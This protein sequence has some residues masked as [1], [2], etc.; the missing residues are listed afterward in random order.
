MNTSEEKIKETL[1]R[2]VGE[3]IEPEHLAKALRSGKKLRVKFGIDPTSPDLHL[4]HAVILRKLRQ[5][6]S[7]GHKAVL[8]IGDFTARIGDPSGREGARAPLT[9][10]EIEKN[11][12]KYL[13]LAG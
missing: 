8:I 12:K 3:V 2:G 6:Q 7:A 5:F 10:K 4:G 9:Q 13:Y 1:G 11:M